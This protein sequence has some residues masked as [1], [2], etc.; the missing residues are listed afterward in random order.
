MTIDRQLIFIAILVYFL[1]TMIIGILPYGRRKI[2]TLETFHTAS[3]NIGTG[4]LILCVI[5]SVYTS[6]TWTAWMPQVTSLGI[7]SIYAC[8]YVLL[9]G[10]FYYKIAPWVYEEGQRRPFLTLA[11]FLN[12]IFED[13]A[14][15]VIASILSF[16]VGCIWITL[17]LKTLGI[18]TSSVFD[19]RISTAVA[20]LVGLM[21]VVFY[22]VWG[23]LESCIWTSVLQGGIVLIGGI[24]I[25]VAL[26]YNKYG[27]IHGFV[28]LLKTQKLGDMGSGQKNVSNLT[29]WTSMI[30]VSGGGMIC[31]PQLFPRMCMG[32]KAGDQKRIGI[33]LACAS[34][35]CLSFIFIGLVAM[36]EGYTEQFSN[37]L[38]F[39]LMGSTGNVPLICATYIVLLSA[40]LG[41]LDI[42]LLSVSTIVTSDML[43]RIIPEEK[44]NTGYLLASRILI[45]GIALVCMSL[46]LI[47]NMELFLLAMGSYDYQVQI[48]PLLVYGLTKGKTVKKTKV[49]LAA[50]V[51]GLITT[52]ALELTGIRVLSLAPG[53][54]GLVINSSILLFG[55]RYAEKRETE[56]CDP[57]TAR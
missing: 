6:S 7:G 54:V 5:S 53:F 29:F 12:G 30:V 17:E 14:I 16:I 48:F 35:W 10:L 26:I 50:L 55:S 18:V 52:A 37:V 44:L 43:S 40:A 34:F 41:T 19:Y 2:N 3:A 23:G 28:D 27:D 9:A 39:E 8:I 24:V 32:R 42:T 15:R 4:A 21:V 31:L 36:D 56:L 20:I 47:Q 45:I 11:G 13:K 57:A 49:P 25:A 38:I 22:V 51:A 33:A 1:A 46:A